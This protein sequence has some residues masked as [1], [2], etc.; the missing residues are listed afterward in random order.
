MI[1]WLKPNTLFGSTMITGNFWAGKTFWTFAEIYSQIDKDHDYLVIANLP[2]KCVDIY[3]N[4]R[5]DFCKVIDHMYYYFTYTNGE[6][7]DLNKYKKIIFVMDEAHLYFP[8]RQAMDKTRKDIWNKV[9][10]V[11][12]Q[13]RKRQVKFYIITQRAQKV[14]IEF[15]RLADFI[16]YYKFDRFFWLPINRLSVIK[17]WWWLNDLIWEDG[18]T[19]ENVEQLE[20]DIVYKWIAKHNTFYFR[21]ELKI[22]HLKRPLWKEKDLTNHICWIRP[23]DADGNLSDEADSVYNLTWDEFHEKLLIKP[24][25]I[26]PFKVLRNRDRIPVLSFWYKWLD[27]KNKVIKTYM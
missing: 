4:S 14:D 5:N 3:Y 15:R 26:V 16:W 9:N 21:R 10:V 1:W 18:T 23:L 13:C 19:W 12:T 2:Y 22:A 6:I 17:S 20:E 24:S 25:R 11:L 7:H 27:Y 8:S